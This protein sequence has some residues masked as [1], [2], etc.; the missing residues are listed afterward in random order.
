MARKFP[1]FTT[2]RQLLNRIEK[3]EARDYD[4]DIK[5]TRLLDIIAESGGEA[6]SPERA[7]KNPAVL[8]V[9]SLRS[10]LIASLPKPIYRRTEDG[11]EE[12]K[13]HPLNKILTH[14]PNPHMNA[15]TFWETVNTHLDL[16]GNAYVYI[17]RYNGRVR[18]LTPIFPRF[19]TV[20][21]DGGK[22]K[23]KVDGTKDTVLDKT[24][25]PDKILHFKDMSLDGVKGQSRVALANRAI[26]I[27]QSA[28]KFGKAFFDKGGNA[29]GIIEMEGQMSPDAVKNFSEH[30]NLN[31]DHGT[32]ILDMGK[33]Y[34]QLS[35]PMADAQFKDVQEWCIQEIAR[36]WDVPSSLI[37][38][39][40]RSTFSNITHLD[41]QWTKYSLGPATD[42]YEREIEFKLMTEPDEMVRFD[43]DDLLKGDVAS[44]AAWYAALKQNKI[45]TTN[46]IR[47]KENMNPIEGGDVLENPATSSDKSTNDE[48]D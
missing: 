31:G 35:I 43:M 13:D 41:L 42:R 5:G 23:Y 12:I 24:H 40:S 17:S 28:Q 30:W 22:V 15:F 34:K 27:Y 2:R 37:N 48:K 10:R 32:P 18:A 7:I 4:F 21:V 19:V 25:S 33:K 46:E 20:E 6:I 11:I 3:L 14:Q 16:F 39:N 8:A 47:L 38:E 26:D 44:R 1:Y 29:K 36:A 45:A 9:I